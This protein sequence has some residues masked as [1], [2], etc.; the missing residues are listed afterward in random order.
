MRVICIIQNLNDAPFS[1]SAV[2]MG[3]FSDPIRGIGNW[4]LF[5]ISLSCRIFTFSHNLSQIIIMLICK[6]HL[7]V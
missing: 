2:T 1:V 5:S 6:C 4:M 7:G 3:I